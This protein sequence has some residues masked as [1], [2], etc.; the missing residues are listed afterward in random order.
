MNTPRVVATVLLAAL[1]PG[2]SSC[3]FGFRAP[4]PDV[5]PLP[6]VRPQLPE[7]ATV[8]EGIKLWH[9]HAT[10]V[11]AVSLIVHLPVGAVDDP[12]GKA[13]L[14]A[15][16]ATMLDE[17]A[18]E[19]GAL[20]LAD[21]IDFLGASLGVG[22]DHEGTT[23]SLQVLRR[24]LEPALDI[25]AD[26]LLRPRF[27]EK[28]WNRV[29]TLW[30]N[31]LVQRN[32]N[33]SLVARLVGNRVFFGDEHP[34]GRPV[35]GYISSVESIELDDVKAF[36]TQRYRPG[37][38][39]VVAAGDIETPALAALLAARFEG[40]SD[41]GAA[42]ASRS[43]PSIPPERP[44]LVVVDKPGSTQTVIR[45]V[46]PGISRHSPDYTELSLLN[47]IFGGSFTSRLMSNL[48]ETHG[49]T[50]G[51]GSG[52]MQMR[53]QG[54]FVSGTPVRR[55]VTGESLAELAKEYRRI[56][57]GP[58]T[59]DE[60]NKARSSL[61]QG[62]VES[63]ETLAGTVRRFANLAENGLD[64]LEL[65]RFLA[66]IESVDRKTLV[67]TAAKYIDWDAAT[68]VLIGDRATIE[69][70]VPAIAADEAEEILVVDEEGR[71]Q[72]G[73]TGAR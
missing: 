11:P 57:A 16:T 7:T 43:I 20:E 22:A 32:E 50:Y 9:V 35:S 14:A 29:K 28:E 31:D 6:P 36:Y 41:R 49:Y 44:R 33:P 54:T 40:W 4:L 10:Q 19:R 67:D 66:E 63:F 21:E 61:R 52:F 51:A 42:P 70:Q 23:V 25:L 3:W 30:S 73:G 24:N 17:G 13:G 15:L 37:G 45:V 59:S 64:P 27:E 71:R 47:V 68:I 5:P 55:D 60:I 65:T 12:A 38:V 2:L 62:V 8:R 69:P 48:R 56:A 39:T 72:A 46:G 18:G 26:V 53:G 1:V 58:I 34:Y